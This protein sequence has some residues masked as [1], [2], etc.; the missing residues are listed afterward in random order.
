MDD[1]YIVKYVYYKDNKEHC[2]CTQS[3]YSFGE[4]IK[5]LHYCKKYE[6]VFYPRE[7]GERINE[8]DLDNLSFGEFVKDFYVTFGNDDC[9]PTIVVELSWGEEC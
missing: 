9:L 1:R 8:K 6:V 5:Y 4:M 7:D 2:V 3:S